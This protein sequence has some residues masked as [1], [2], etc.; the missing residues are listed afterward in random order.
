MNLHSGY[1][2]TRPQ[3]ANPNPHI[4]EGGK[5]AADTPKG[6]HRRIDSS[7]SDGKAESQQQ[8]GK[9]VNRS[10]TTSQTELINN[11]FALLLERRCSLL[12]SLTPCHVCIK[13]QKPSA[14]YSEE[15]PRERRF[16]LGSSQTT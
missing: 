7:E 16:T 9:R 13:S 4:L 10:L 3:A 5:S 12:L 14:V 6:C 8:N 1:R 11:A 15:L 2:N